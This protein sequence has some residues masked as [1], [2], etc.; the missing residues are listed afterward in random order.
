MHAVG[1][2]EELELHAVSNDLPLGWLSTAEVMGSPFFGIRRVG[3]RLAF[4]CAVGV[5]LHVSR[6]RCSNR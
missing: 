5:A 4:A 2:H 6:R 1:R 3:G